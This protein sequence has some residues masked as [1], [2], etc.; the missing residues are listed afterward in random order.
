IS[1]CC[2][3]REVRDLGGRRE[4]ARDDGSSRL[5][6]EASEH[7]GA[8]RRMEK[9]RSVAAAAPG[10]PTR[11]RD[12]SLSSSAVLRGSPMLRVEKTG[13]VVIP[14][15]VEESADVIAIETGRAERRRCGIAGFDPHRRG[16]AEAL[17]HAV[18]GEVDAG[19]PVVDAVLV[20][21]PPARP[22]SSPSAR[23]KKELLRA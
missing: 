6:R 16:D 10:D 8:P 11:A 4:V 5:Q 21:A 19:D 17:G 18:A 2:S 22:P 7:I 13:Q 1:P 3:P 9:K 20:G 12:R 15:L 14:G 23:M